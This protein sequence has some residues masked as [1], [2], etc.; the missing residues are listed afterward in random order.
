MQPLVSLLRVNKAGTQPAYLQLSMQLAGLIKKGILPAGYKLMSSRELAAG[1]GLNRATVVKAYDELLSQGWV[2]SF[3]GNGTFVADNLPDIRSTRNLKPDEPV[4]NPIKTAGFHLN[5]M[6]YLDRPVLT[7][8][9]GLHLDDGFPD[10][11]LA[12]LSELSRAYRTQLL[13]GNAYSKLGY[14]D[15]KGS[16]RLREQLSKYLNESRGL[17]TTAQNILITRGTM[18]AFYLVI[19]ALVQK[20]DHIIMGDTGWT[21][22]YMSAL[23]SGANLHRVRVDEHGLDID[24][25]ERLCQKEKVRMV[26]IT[27]HHHYPTTVA[28][29]ADRRIKLLQLANQ[30]GFIVFEDDYD[31]E[32]HYLNK[33]LMPLAGSDHQGM[34]LYCGSFSKSISPAFRVG[35]ICGPEDAI[36]HLA[37][38]RRV[39]DRQGDLMLENAIAEL[40]EFG[41][42]QRHLRKSMRV[43]KQ[44]RDVFCELLTNNI[45][46]KIE[47]KI[48]DGGLAIWAKFD[49]VI[50]LPE[51]AKKARQRGLTLSDGTGFGVPHH[52]RLGFA[53]SNQQELEESVDILS[54]II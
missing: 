18:M 13:T 16:F 12:P 33:P 8:L 34:V 54:K 23:N 49:P 15:T 43:Y 47:F 27:S 24:A 25:V 21:A 42:V 1:M 5:P 6:P 36:S 29:R 32:F 46:G 19:T 38:L 2:E 17:K 52:T 22:A 3:T 30:Y 26:Y 39:I 7:S 14:D 11:G 53:S 31:Y 35:F 45:G 4:V 28:L 51:L 40:L 41:L 10:S 50:D 9:P 44:R 37:T 48:P 20:G